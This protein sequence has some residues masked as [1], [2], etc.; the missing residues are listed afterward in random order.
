[1]DNTLQILV[2]SKNIKGEKRVLM[3]NRDIVC[4]YIPNSSVATYKSNNVAVYLLIGTDEQTNED[5]LYVG[6][7]EESVNRLRTHKQSKIFWDSAYVFY[8]ATN[9]LTKSDFKYL[10]AKI[11][12]KVKESNRY[13]LDNSSIPKQSYVPEVRTYE[14]NDIL[15]TIEFIL[16][17][18]FHIFPFESLSIEKTEDSGEVKQQEEIF[19][20]TEKGTNAKGYLLGEGKRFVVLKG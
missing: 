15:Q 9:Q 12:Q 3:S 20:L 19:Y 1:M 2:N 11:Y 16:G 18:A 10:E 14:L 4:D 5:L 7:T 8:S 17:G 6:E 13:Q